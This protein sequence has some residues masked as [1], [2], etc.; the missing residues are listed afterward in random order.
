MHTKPASRGKGCEAIHEEL[1]AW[2]KGF[3][4][5]DDF[6]FFFNRREEAERALAVI[7]KC[8]SSFELQINASKTRIVEVRELVQE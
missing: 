1:G 5:V 7:I 8:V 2:P 3:R 6:T 4:Y